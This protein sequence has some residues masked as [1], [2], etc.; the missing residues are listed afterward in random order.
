MKAMRLF[1]AARLLLAAVMV[2]AVAPAPVQAI[3]AAQRVII[4][5]QPPAVVSPV[6]GYVA[7]IVSGFAVAPDAGRQACIT[8]YVTTL[9]DTG[10]WAKL[11]WLYVLAAGEDQGSR[12]NWKNP[13]TFNV[14]KT[15]TPTFTTDQGWSGSA[16]NYLD[17]GFNP[18]TAG[19]QFQ[20]NAGSFWAATLTDTNDVSTAQIAG[21]TS[22]AGIQPRSSTGALVTI[23]QSS[24]SDTGS[25]NTGKGLYGWN[26]SASGA[27]DRYKNGSLVD[28][29]T[30]TSLALPNVNFLILT[31]NAANY[32]TKTVSLAALGGA[33]TSGQV[34]AL[35][36]G[37]AAY[38]TCIGQ[39]AT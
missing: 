5:G 6:P 13:G 27:Y 30:R 23:S 36:T 32:T 21:A 33:M 22:Y 34:S 4:L 24:G 19:G 25:A 3:P 14:A 39:S 20:R 12:V 18:S 38:M 15:G 7:A 11:D 16:S 2:L 9:Y 1:T 10:T 31:H 28:S 8:A 26:R 17:T 37:Y 29:P 35:W